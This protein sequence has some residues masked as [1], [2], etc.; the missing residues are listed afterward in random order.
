[1]P[2]VFDFIFEE[3]ENRRR[4]SEF[5]EFQV[6]VQFLELYGDDIR[7]LLDVSAID[8]KTGHSQKVLK[9]TEAKNGSIS[10]SGLKAELVT[11]K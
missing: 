4:Q 9:I 1:M 2:R 11:S 3:I 5:S 7:D 8:P 10:V 6:K